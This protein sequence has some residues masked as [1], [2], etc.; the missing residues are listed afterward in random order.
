M[1]AA[2]GGPGHHHSIADYQAGWGI[3]GILA[4]F[5]VRASAAG[6][7]TFWHGCREIVLIDRKT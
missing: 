4:G 2:S 1:V 7:S 5:R 6:G 3:Q